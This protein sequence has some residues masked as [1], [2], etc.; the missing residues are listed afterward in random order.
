EILVG[1]PAIRNII[2]EGTVHQIPS[3]MQVGQKDGMQTM[4]A[5]LVD[6]ANRGIISREEAQ[7][8]SM[9]PNLFPHAAPP[10]RITTGRFS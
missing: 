4:D 10:G 1:T 5:A 7:T 6:L 2:R 8:K 3:A 9:K